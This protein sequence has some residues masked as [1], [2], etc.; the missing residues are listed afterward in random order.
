MTVGMFHICAQFKL[1]LKIYKMAPRRCLQSLYTKAEALK[2][3]EKYS[4]YCYLDPGNEY[5]DLT[6]ETNNIIY[7]NV[8][9]TSMSNDT[10]ASN[11]LH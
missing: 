7:N 1:S 11:H 10:P 4:K 8:S 9:N 2:N 6:F 5:C 3:T